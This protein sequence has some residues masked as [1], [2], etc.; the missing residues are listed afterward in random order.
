MPFYLIFSISP[1]PRNGIS[2]LLSPNSPPLAQEGVGEA[3]SFMSAT[4]TGD[5]SSDWSD[6]N[7]VLDYVLLHEIEEHGGTHVAS[8]PRLNL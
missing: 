2:L 6:D 7:E 3:E 5:S 8:P 1:I 4:D